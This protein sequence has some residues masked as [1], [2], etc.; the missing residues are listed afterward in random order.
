MPSEKTA[1]VSERK[2]LKNRKIRNTTRTIATKSAQAL[3]GGQLEDAEPAVIQAVRALDR[4][5]GKGILHR[6]NASRKKSRLMAKLNALK[7]SA[8][9]SP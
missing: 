7:E 8:S 6:N 3:R 9:S 2:R 5:A 1:R 4:A